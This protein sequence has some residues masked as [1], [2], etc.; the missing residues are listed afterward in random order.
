MDGI[1]TFLTFLGGILL[2]LGLPL[3]LTF[4]V[5]WWLRKLDARWQ[6][7]ASLVQPANPVATVH[8]WEKMGCSTEKREKCAAYQN[9]EMPCWQHFRDTNRQLKPACIGCN[10]LQEA[11]I[12]VYR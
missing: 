1:N 8:C 10:V 6:A 2:R 12:P 5:F 11:P 4:A 3:G 7:E 9:Q